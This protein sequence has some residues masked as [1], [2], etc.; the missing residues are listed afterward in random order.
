[1]NILGVGAEELI[2][3]FLLA[4]IFMGPKRMLGW[5]YQ[6]GKYFAKFRAM[7]EETMA[8]IR[9]EFE[10]AQIDLPADMKDLKLTNKR[11]NIVDEANKL[12][13]TELNR[14]ST[15]KPGATA[16]TTDG[17]SANPAKPD[18][19]PVAAPEASQNGTSAPA[20]DANKPSDDEQ[21]RYDAWLPK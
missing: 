5:T 2:L 15:T 20:T 18:S 10:A 19:P 16:T 14:P 8:A 4:L 9:K 3:I 21:N 6:A 11:F 7:V 13:N 17:A 1:M 12:V